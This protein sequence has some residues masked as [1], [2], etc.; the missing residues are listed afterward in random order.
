MWTFAPTHA[1]S[2][3]RENVQLVVESIDLR[4]EGELRG[5]LTLRGAT[6]PF[7][8]AI[9]PADVD[10]LWPL[11]R[12]AQEGPGSG[13]VGDTEVRY[14]SGIALVMDRGNGMM[15]RD[16]NL[17]QLDEVSCE[18]WLD[19]D[20]LYTLRLG[21]IGGTVQSADGSGRP[22]PADVDMRSPHVANLPAPDRP[23]AWVELDGLSFAP[24]STLT[25]RLV[26]QRPPLEDGS[27]PFDV[28]GRFEA[29]VCA[30]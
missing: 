21:D 9:C 25:G 29:T 12:T 11:A 6:G 24:G 27:R 10:A 19:Q 4:E 5:T 18:T 23:A 28:S 20:V 16:L 22:Q 17:F 1:V 7:R 30:L 13:V 15:I 3:A 26:A 2:L 8:A 14:P